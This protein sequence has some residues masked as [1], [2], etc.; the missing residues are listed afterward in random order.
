MSDG[1]LF[2]IIA[3]LSLV[4]AGLFGRAGKTRLKTENKVLKTENDL[5]KDITPIA[6]NSAVKKTEI[7][8]AYEETMR[9]IDKAGKNNDIDWLKRIAS[10]MAQ[11]ALSMGAKERKK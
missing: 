9:E 2:S 8:D 4:V 11:K 6:V 1:I 3:V 7:E 5:R 10:E